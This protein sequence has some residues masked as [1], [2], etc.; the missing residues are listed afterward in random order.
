MLRIGKFLPLALGL[1]LFGGVE[2][3]ILSAPF[4]RPEHIGAFVGAMVLVAWSVVPLIPSNR[5][6]VAIVLASS[7]TVVLAM[8]G[9]GIALAVP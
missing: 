5:R 6:R 8:I 3:W 9:L 2:V 4:L 1:V 7:A